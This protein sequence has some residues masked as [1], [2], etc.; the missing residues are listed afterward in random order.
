VI[1][2]A[3]A[4][5]VLRFAG[6]FLEVFSGEVDQLTSL[7]GWLGRKGRLL[8]FFRRTSGKVSEKYGVEFLTLLLM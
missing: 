8:K 3:P 4:F 5:C 2:T 7:V 6:E 1:K